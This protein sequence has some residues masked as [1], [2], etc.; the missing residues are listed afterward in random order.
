MKED[1]RGSFRS[2]VAISISISLPALMSIGIVL[3]NYMASMGLSI[4]AIGY[5]Y[6]IRAVVRALTRLLYGA[7]QAKF[8]SEKSLFIGMLV[9]CLAFYILFTASNTAL[10]AT[11]ILV[12]AVSEG[13]I[14]VTFLSATAQALTDTAATALGFGLA[15]SI[16]QSPTIIAPVLTGY[17]ADFIG[18]GN[19]FAIASILS[20]TS[21]LISL[22][23]QVD[24]QIRRK[25]I[26]HS[27]RS[28]RRILNKKFTLLLIATS[29]FFASISS[30]QPVFSY[31]IINEMKLSYAILGLIVSIGSFIALFSR[32]YTG[33]L[34][35][36]FGCINILILVGFL[37]SILVLMLP[38]S[39]NAWIIASIYALRR[40]IMAAPPR[41]ALIANMFPPE[42]YGLAYGLI[43]ASID[44]GRIIGP[45]ITGLIIDSYGFHMG[46]I[47]M[48][49]LLALFSLAMLILKS[50]A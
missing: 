29:I 4:A 39:N 12:L 9:R 50:I 17:I 1:S 16:R 27:M 28:F 2:I 41:N 21:A 35:D 23:I 30:F 6:S 38:L 45:A 3:P 24:G 7:V 13:L 25:E 22:K 8:P 11:G 47:F 15:L 46:F 10:I 14:E 44:I 26:G 37:R 32:I 20:L 48:A 40:S 34:A 18:L 33:Y 19:V 49:I 43:G 5:L 42:H 36:R 31:W